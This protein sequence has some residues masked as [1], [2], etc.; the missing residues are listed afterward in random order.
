M[1]RIRATALHIG[2]SVNAHAVQRY[3]ATAD[4]FGQQEIAFDF[5]IA[6][7]HARRADDDV[8]FDHGHAFFRSVCT[9]FIVGD[10]F[11]R[12][13][14]I[15]QHDRF[16]TSQRALRRE[17]SVAVAFQNAFLHGC[18]NASLTPRRN[19]I[20]IREHAES[21]GTF[22]IQ[23]QDAR[24]HN[25]RFFAGHVSRR[26]ERTSA[27]YNVSGL[28]RFGYVRKCPVC[29]RHVFERR[30]RQLFVTEQAIDHSC[31]FRTADRPI[32]LHR[33]VRVALQITLIQPLLNLRFCPMPANVR[34][35]RRRRA[36]RSYR[37]ER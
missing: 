37:T 28:D 35:S 12:I 10:R 19:S 8:A 9:R 31:E 2:R 22:G 6:Q 21:A 7:R 27:A 36:G 20:S 33:S 1:N 3:V 13:S 16:C 25:R 29:H 32:R 23:P 34:C 15:Q 11:V 26:T 17:T 4:A 24:D 14:R 5:R 18:R 30:V